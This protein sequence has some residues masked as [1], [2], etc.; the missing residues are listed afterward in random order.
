VPSTS[1][2]TVDDVKRRVPLRVPLQDLEAEDVKLRLPLQ[3]FEVEDVKRRVPLRVP[4]I[5][6]DDSS[7]TPRSGS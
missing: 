1:G 6:E 4:N 7:A 3:V 5:A 2:I